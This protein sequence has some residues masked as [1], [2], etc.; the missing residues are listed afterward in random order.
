MSATA[1]L[2]QRNLV[3]G[4]L[5]DAVDGATREIL[6]PATGEVIAR[7]PE[8]SAADVERAV[9]AARAARIP[10]RDATPGRRQELLLALADTIDRHGEELAALE[11]LNVG[12][13]HA[14]AAEELPICADELRFFAGAARTMNGPAAGE[15]GAG[16]T[17]MVR[18]EPLGIVGQIAPWNYPLMMA[19]WK[20]APALAGG[21]TV[22]LKPS[23]LTP[24]ST[25]RFAELVA[26]ILPPGVLNV[27]TGDGPGV[28]EAIVRH[29]E[30]A[31]VSLTG[32]VQTGKSIARAAADTLKRVHLE[33]GGKAP[34]IVFED[35]DP[36]A[37]A[38]GLRVASFLNSG[39][40]CTA[41]SRVLAAPGIYEALLEELVPAVASLN[42]GDPAAG[43]QI[44]MGP[45][46]SARQ[47]QRVLGFLDRATSAGAQL[48]TG[49]SAGH[50]RGFFVEPTVVAGVGQQSEIVQSEVFGP[51]VTVQRLRD[52]SEAFALAN[53]VPYG[54]AASVWT[55]DTG[56]AMEAIRQLDFG[57]VWINDHLPFLSEM[58]HGGFK[59][60]GYGKDLSVYALEDYTRVKHAMIKLE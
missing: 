25:L 3:G 48:L 11:S 7:V 45:V 60:S 8:G 40:D 30:I 19:I 14:L 26:D 34:V 41:A 39:Q 23:E 4:E 52:A 6:N 12:K 43:A 28:G 24:I 21:N 1:V 35:A 22:V 56:T 5:L 13:P 18:R 54:L 20:I 58:P 37:V 29:P 55:R 33:L 2:Q 49:G 9:A 42:V 50:D 10:W 16:Y 17:S 32:S 51:V 44:E 36:K 27:V 59:E 47:Q 46:I 38:A 31:L 53:D 57:C 15:Y